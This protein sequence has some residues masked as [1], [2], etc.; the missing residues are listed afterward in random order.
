MR[1]MQRMIGFAGAVALF[2]TLGMMGETARSRVSASNS[3]LSFLFCVFSVIIFEKISVKI[4]KRGAWKQAISVVV[5]FL[6]STALTVGKRLETVENFNVTEW[7]AWIVI[8]ILTIYFV[9]LISYVWERIDR[10]QIRDLQKVGKTSSSDV[11]PARKNSFLTSSFLRNWLIIFLCWLPVFLAFYPGAFVYDAQDEYV[12]VATRQFTT[13]HPLMHVLLLGGMVCAGNKFG[14]SYNIGIA[15][16]TL[17]QMILLS[18]VFSYTT[19]YIKTKRKGLEKTCVIFY[20]F[21]P[22]ISMYAVC[23]AKDGLFTAAFLVVIVKMLQFF[24]NPKRFMENKGNR[25][26]SIL[27]ATAMMLLRNN[28]M[29]AY[30]VWIP[31]VIAGMLLLK[32]EKKDYMEITGV[33]I[34]SVVCF[35]LC[36]KLLTVVTGASDSES[37]EIMTVPIQQ[38]V[39]TYVYSPEVYSEEEKQILFEMIPEEDMDLYNPRLSDLVKSKFNNQNFNEDKGKYLG[40]WAKIGLRKPLVY[41]NAWLMTSYGYWYPDTVINVYGGNTVH[42]FTYQD[43]SY[44]GFET[45]NPGVRES[46]F[47]WLEEQFRRMSLE[48]YQQQVP[49]ISMLFSPGFLFWCFV[50]CAGFLLWKQKWNKVVPF[51]GIFLLWLTVVLGPTY[52]VRYVLILWFAIPV[53]VTEMK[54]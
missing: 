45:E 54:S 11:E 9:P 50:F 30:L 6:F 35:L 39:R 27:A 47:P 16:Y 17:F 53:I 20:G 49:G 19:E 1:L 37:Q 43:S 52:L 51:A 23:S 4:E 15:M 34:G 3:F 40:L 22:V 46:K 5:S 2:D 44:F 29:Y 14:G 26:A 41:L 48:L 42:T 12:Q 36:S 10:V 8:G 24:E 28:G 13:H 7:K 32:K 31:I 18:G 33:M 21:F 38:M 25:T